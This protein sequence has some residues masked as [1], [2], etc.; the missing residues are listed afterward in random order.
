LKKQRALRS[1]SED[2]VRNKSGE[3]QTHQGGPRSG[4]KRAKS[5]LHKRTKIDD[6]RKDKKPRKKRG[7]S[8]DKREDM[9]RKGR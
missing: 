2:K 4:T 7:K 5:E 9:T 8:G 1:K 6:K 3:D